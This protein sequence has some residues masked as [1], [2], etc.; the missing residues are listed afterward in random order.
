MAGKRT[1]R[2]AG[3]NEES[4]VIDRIPGILDVGDDRIA[5]LLTHRQQ[6]LAAAFSDNANG[7]LLPIKVAEAKPQDIAGS[8]TD[9]GEQ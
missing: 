1:K 4:V 3:A 6:G 2:C 5:N 9:A 7:G 8:K